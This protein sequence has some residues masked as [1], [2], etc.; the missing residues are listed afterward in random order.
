MAQ[1]VQSQRLTDVWG[2]TLAGCLAVASLSLPGYLQ[3]LADRE[4]TFLVTA[5][6]LFFSGVVMGFLRPV[7]VW[8]WPLASMLAFAVWDVLQAAR[9]PDFA[10]PIEPGAVADVLAASFSGDGLYALPV[11]VGALAGATM[12]RAGMD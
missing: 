5:A 6:A 10:Y 9:K 11:L 7:R 12:I 1:T 8:R 2:W 3:V 4:A